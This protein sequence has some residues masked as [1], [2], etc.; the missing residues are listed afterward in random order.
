VFF[1]SLK[2]AVSKLFFKVTMTEWFRDTAFGQIVRLATRNK[3]F[4]YSEENDPE[5]WKKWV[6]EQKSGY[7]AHH[8]SIE[9]H[10]D[11]SDLDEPTGLGGIRTREAKEKDIEN[12]GRDSDASPEPLVDN[13]TYNR[14]SGVRIDP[15][16]GRDIHLIEFLP[17]DSEVYACL[18]FLTKAYLLT[19]SYR[20]HETG[21]RARSSS[22][23]LRFVS[24]PRAYISGLRSTALVFPTSSDNFRSARSLPLSVYRCLLQVMD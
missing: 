9:P 7:A 15:E 2:N 1:A 5:L 18:G 17:D 23:P 21:P 8:G 16:K 13:G 22:S 10:A 14:A 12:G 3:Y 24:L 19:V 20:I 6:N 11:D 4:K